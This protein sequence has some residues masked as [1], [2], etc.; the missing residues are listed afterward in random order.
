VVSRRWIG[1]SCPL[2]MSQIFI[3]SWRSSSVILLR[4]CIQDGDQLLF[5]N[6][7]DLGWPAEASSEFER[8]AASPATGRNGRYSVDA[9]QPIRESRPRGAGRETGHEP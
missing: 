8:A 4:G 7:D 6:R 2:F 1:H 3:G 5:H 9:P